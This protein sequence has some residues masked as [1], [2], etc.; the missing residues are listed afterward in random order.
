MQ[1]LKSAVRPGVLVLLSVVVYWA[2]LRYAFP[3]YFAPLVPHHPDLYAPVGLLERSWLEVLTYPRPLAFLIL[4][5]DGMFGLQGSILIPILA[6]LILAIAVAVYVSKWSQSQP[7]WPAVACYFVIVFAHPE[8]Y[9]EHRHDIPVSLT[10]IMLLAA[11]DCWRNWVLSRQ[12]RQ[13]VLALF[14]I[15][16]LGTT[17]ETYFASVAVL[18][19]G[20]AIVE[21]KFEVRRLMPALL[22]VAATGGLALAITVLGFRRWVTAPVQGPN[23]YR[24]SLSPGDLFKSLGFYT[25][26]LFNFAAFLVLAVVVFAVLKNRRHLLLAATLLLSGL[27]ALLP[28]SA[29]PNHAMAEYSWDAV[30]LTFAPVLLIGSWPLLSLLITAA[31]GVWLWANQPAYRTVAQEWQIEQEAQNRQIVA[32][33]PRLRQIDASAKRIL[34]AGLNT[35]F[36]PW[37]SPD[38]VRHEL[39]E[40]AWTLVVPPDQPESF[41]GPVRSIHAGGVQPSYF[42]AAIG[43]D[44]KGRLVQVLNHG[45]LAQAAGDSVAIPELSGLAKQLADHPHD[46][47][48]LLDAG[49]VYLHWG[50]FD[51]AIQYLQAAVDATGGKNP[52]PYFF[53]AKSYEGKQDPSAALHYY[54][55]AVHADQPPLNLLFQQAV[56]RL[57]AAAKSSP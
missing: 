44:A 15:V 11:T 17:K 1:T 39:G 7:G 55:L 6:T 2:C 23:S 13:L 27:A 30:P 36:H 16:L 28:N 49:T 43:F 20:M 34:V 12:P 54:E 50:M 40:H 57:K 32:S 47:A 4:R 22:A 18:F 41:S 35:P 37:L 42:D 31:T 25:H 24:V 3:G 9:F 33:L 14:L 38:F 52:Y 10:C 45:E 53:I 46:G 21:K 51:K 26:H 29:L 8:F 56:D 19:L 48:A 5:F